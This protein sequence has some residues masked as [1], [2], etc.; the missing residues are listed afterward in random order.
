[1]ES[2]HAR[3]ER[4]GC[5]QASLYSPVNQASL[6]CPSSRAFHRAKCCRELTT[7]QRHLFQVDLSSIPR[8]P[9]LSRSWCSQRTAQ[10]LLSSTLCASVSASFPVSLRPL[11]QLPLTMYS[12][13]RCLSTIRSS[14]PLRNQGF[15]CL[16]NTKNPSVPQKILS[17]SFLV[18]LHP[19]F[20][21]R[22]FVNAS[23]AQSN[24][25]ATISAYHR[26]RWAF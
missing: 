12:R 5:H 10:L 13:V 17:E 21:K 9:K 24:P 8:S 18:S 3:L 11:V 1:M 4:L 2:Y 6:S 7:V 19:P 20:Q 26:Q 15:L 22:G 14:D 23:L 16:W 25:F